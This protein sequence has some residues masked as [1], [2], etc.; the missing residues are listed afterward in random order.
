MEQEKDLP[1]T[2]KTARM[3]ET[4]AA[5]AAPAVPERE[6]LVVPRLVAAEGGREKCTPTT[7]TS[8][9]GKKAVDSS[10]KLFPQ[11]LILIVSHQ[12]SILIQYL[13]FTCPIGV[14]LPKLSHTTLYSHCF[15]CVSLVMQETISRGDQRVKGTSFGDL[16]YSGGPLTHFICCTSSVD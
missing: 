7:D 16:G 10:V 4:A 2:K 1:W 3:T 14:H 8:A 9:K 13:A 11:K 12:C 15:P 6:R 5:P